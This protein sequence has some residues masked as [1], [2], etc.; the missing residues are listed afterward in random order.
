MNTATPAFCWYNNDSITYADIYGPLYNWFTIDKFS[1]G[2]K[3]VCP[4]GWH[5]PNNDE[6]NELFNYLG[7]DAVAGGKMKQ[8][9]TSLWNPPNSGAT[10]ESGFTALPGGKRWVDGSS[11]SFFMEGGLFTCWSTDDCVNNE[12]YNLEI[13]YNDLYLY[14]HCNLLRKVNNGSSLRCLKD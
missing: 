14:L 11:V 1:N 5:V 13:Y 4:V 8:T 10:N 6:W 7:G 12:A 2:N 3:N 9:G